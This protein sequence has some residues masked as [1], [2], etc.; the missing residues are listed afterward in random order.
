MKLNREKYCEGDGDGATRGGFDRL[1]VAGQALGS[2][3]WKDIQK[4]SRD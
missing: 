1:G 3:D 2:D 4:V